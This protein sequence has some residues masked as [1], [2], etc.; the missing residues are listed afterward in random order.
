MFK[1]LTDFVRSIEIAAKT[2]GNLQGQY[3][4]SFTPIDNFADYRCE[5]KQ[6]LLSYIRETKNLE[7]VPFKQIFKKVILPNIQSC[8]IRKIGCQRDKVYESLSGLPKS[9]G[10]IRTDLVSLLSERLNK[11]TELLKKITV[12]KI[13]LL[14]DAYVYSDQEDYK[15]CINQISEISALESFH[16][17][18]VIG[19]KGAFIS[20]V[21]KK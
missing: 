14:L 5:I 13:L 11:K 17:V 1:H 20:T 15:N 7:T 2:E 3:V 9:E 8:A 6:G 12:P 19:E 18:F 21:F 16:T 4:V 10:D